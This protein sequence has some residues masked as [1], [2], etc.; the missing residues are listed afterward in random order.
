VEI[1]A[2]YSYDPDSDDLCYHWCFSD[3]SVV[4]ADGYNVNSPKIEALFPHG[5]T[6]ATLT[7]VDR[8]GGV[9]IHD[10]KVTVQDTTPPAVE[11]TTNVAALWPPNH[12]M[13]PVLLFVKPTDS[14][15]APGEILPIIVTI[16]S[17]EPDNATG[18]GDGNTTGDVNFCKGYASPVLVTDQLIYVPFLEA[19]TGIVFLRAER[20][21]D[22]DGRKYT[23]DVLAFD[24]EDN[25]NS[26]SCCVVVPHS[27]K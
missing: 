16:S 23:I 6:M 21:G 11:C 12:T 15:A 9:S 1:D 5:V 18:N 20:A 7:V 3:L 8:C 19:Y 26:T 25:V 13:R 17:D 14:C 2:S 27:K 24:D 22:G 4:L 10:V